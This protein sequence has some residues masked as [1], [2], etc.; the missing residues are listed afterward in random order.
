MSTT[1]TTTTS[2]ASQ[3]S[4]AHTMRSLSR[5]GKPEIDIKLDRPEGAPDSHVTSYSTMDKL[6]GT[7]S[8]TARQDQRFENIEIAFV[9]TSITYVDKFSSSPQ[10]SARAD[11]THS[12][13]KLTQPIDHTCLPIPRIAE[14]GRTYRFPFT[15]VIPDQLLPR[16][17]ARA[18]NAQVRAAHAQLP[19]SM[20]DPDVSGHGGKLLDDLTPDMAKVV[21]AIRVTVTRAREPDGKVVVL[22]TKNQKVR[23][24]PAFPEQPPV[25][26]DD[27][28][29]EYHL[30]QERTIRK[31][32]LGGKTGKLTIMAQQPRCFHLPG[33]RSVDNHPI[34]TSANV[35][36]RFDPVDETSQPPRLGALSSKLKATTYYATVSRVEFP[37]KL[38]TMMDMTQGIYA[39]TLPLSSRCMAGAK[40]QTHSPSPPPRRDSGIS[41]CS[42]MQA[43]EYAD[44][45][46]APGIPAPSS[47]YKGGPFYTTNLLIPLT[48][49]T[50]RTFVPSFHACLISRVYKLGLSLTLPGL[51]TT[52][53]L[54]MPIQIASEGSEAG[55]AQIQARADERMAADE[56][57]ELFTPRSTV[58]GGSAERQDGGPPEYEEFLARQPGEGRVGRVSIVA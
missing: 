48:L 37:T 52:A 9:G 56:A 39:E 54:K 57:T 20:G 38:T 27:E 40:W 12:F 55:D 53:K 33:A 25:V 42:N 18:S 58:A 2:S 10:M 8:L 29:R 41:D 1:T 30:R 32:L 21:Y 23:V 51:N 22:T 26:V 15:F 45:L 35:L 11:S 31:G 5:H 49:P 6:Q 34:T 46:L 28:D 44:G 3:T 43:D 19:P 47:C 24:K 13:L 50:N 14:A 17:C 7:V 4:I 36:L 16:S